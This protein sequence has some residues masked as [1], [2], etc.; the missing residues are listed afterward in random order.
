M[1]LWSGTARTHPTRSCLIISG[2]PLDWP[3]WMLAFLVIM[4]GSFLQGV[5]GY[6][7]AL[8]SAPLLFLIDPVLVPAP[9]I[10]VGGILPLLVLASSYRHVV[11]RD[12]AYAWPGGL[13]GV[14]LAYGLIRLLPEDTWQV[15]F[16]TV[17]IIAVLL[18]LLSAS[19]Q[20]GRP[21]IAGASMVAATMGTIT[22]VG[23][24]PLALAYQNAQP[25][26]VRGTLSAIFIPLSVMSLAAL[27][28]LGRFTA[29]DLVLAAALLPAMVIG[30]LLSRRVG[31][32]MPARVFRPVMLT[33]ALT[34]GA[35][36]VVSG[37]I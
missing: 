12:L 34:A 30:F 23:G 2:F 21:L 1:V 32:R 31:R 24:P 17:I 29:A 10:I 37:L 27:W 35:Y 9:L 18:S 6:G 20:P 11:V 13:V 26:R 4:G 36:S 3:L 28:M 15:I 25:Q 8:F 22:A 5:I 14:G 16:G 33:V 19:L 7:V